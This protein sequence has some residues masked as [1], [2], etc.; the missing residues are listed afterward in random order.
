MGG[1]RLHKLPSKMLQELSKKACK[2][3]LRCVHVLW[4]VG[5]FPLVNCYL[6]VCCVQVLLLSQCGKKMGIQTCYLAKTILDCLSHLQ[7]Q[8]N[9]LSKLKR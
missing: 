8:E 7:Q 9:D 3:F 1:K 5:Y 4:K 6:P 2:N